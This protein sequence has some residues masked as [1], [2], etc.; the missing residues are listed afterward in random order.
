MKVKGTIL[1]PKNYETLLK[2]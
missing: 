1:A 2:E